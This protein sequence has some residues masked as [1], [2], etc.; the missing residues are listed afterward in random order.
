MMNEPEARSLPAVIGDWYRDLEGHT[1]EIVAIDEDDATVEIQYFDGTVEE[2][3]FD[4]WAETTVE[5]VEPPE[6][7][8]GSLDIEREDY[9][10]DL[11]DYHAEEW[12][13]PLDMLD[14]GGL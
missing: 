7:W 6:D 4:T 12:N 14:R 5:A 9:G 11:D 8:S 3:D 1:F 13:N 10:V 2:L